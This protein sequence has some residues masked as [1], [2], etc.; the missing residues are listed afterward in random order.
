MECGEEKSAD[1]AC[2]IEG[3]AEVGAPGV[4]AEEAVF[5]AAGAFC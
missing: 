5:A 2:A 4:G 1:A 3:A